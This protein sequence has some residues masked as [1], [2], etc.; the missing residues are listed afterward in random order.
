MRSLLCCWGCP[1]SEG[2]ST[3]G[4]WAS[5]RG[6]EELREA[7]GPAIRIQPASRLTRPLPSPNVLHTLL[8]YKGEAHNASTMSL[9]SSNPESQSSEQPGQKSREEIVIEVNSSLLPPD[10]ADQTC[11]LQ[12]GSSPSSSVGEVFLTALPPAPSLASP[13]C[14]SSVSP[15]CRLSFLPPGQSQEK[16]SST[17]EAS[18]VNRPESLTGVLIYDD[19]RGQARRLPG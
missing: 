10:Q 11:H 15:V 6:M 7:K 3:A 14:L 2:S 16:T 17:T 13:S 12:L 1:K 9:W 19:S 5:S 8:P 4:Q 18:E